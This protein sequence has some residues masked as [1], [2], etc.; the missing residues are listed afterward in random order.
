MNYAS[1]KNVLQEQ[2][3]RKTF[4]YEGKLKEFVSNRHTLKR[5]GKGNSS[6]RK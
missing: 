5:F 1:G 3:E 2:E 6:D 4:S